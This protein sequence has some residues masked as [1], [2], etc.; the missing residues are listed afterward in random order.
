MLDYAIVHRDTLAD[1]QIE[2]LDYMCK[3]YHNAL[4]TSIYEGSNGTHEATVEHSNIASTTN[5]VQDNS[6]SAA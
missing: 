6:V 1:V 4:I 5:D 2:K 3:A